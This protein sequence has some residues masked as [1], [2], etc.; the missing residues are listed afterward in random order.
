MFRQLWFSSFV[1]IVI[2]CLGINVV[3][4]DVV[5]Q[6]STFYAYDFEDA[7]I[8]LYPTS[9]TDEVAWGAISTGS[10]TRVYGGPV[11][12]GN[13]ALRSN[14]LDST[15]T[16]GNAA[17]FSSAM[18]AQAPRS[19]SVSFRVYLDQLD[20]GD[21]DLFRVLE[22]LPGSLNNS[23]TV[24]SFYTNTADQK[25]MFAGAD[26]PF[27]ELASVVLDQWIDV[28]VQ[29]NLD[30][31]TE[32]FKVV[33][34]DGFSVVST[35]IDDSDATSV[36]QINGFVLYNRASGSATASDYNVVYL[37]DINWQVPEPAS[38]GLLLVG[39][40]FILGRRWSNAGS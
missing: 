15:T 25:L 10:K 31:A 26:G 24:F 5:L 34:D 32:T 7:T 11:D 3:Q 37:D 1:S 36:T 22:N 27:V 39:G 19:G 28:V 21:V 6:G 35:T 2:V 14:P 13:K 30:S 12:S 23:N 20:G 29:Y 17:T 9:S 4:A 33:L 38:M 8:G 18:T 16:T 40:V